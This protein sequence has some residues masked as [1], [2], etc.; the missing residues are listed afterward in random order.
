M[1]EVVRSAELI[2]YTA[3]EG[4]RSLGEGKLLLPDSFAGTPRN[5]L[6]LTSKVGAGCRACALR[7]QAEAGS[8]QGKGG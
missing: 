8:D 3:E 1:T 4:V 7:G 6:C 2:D 5:K